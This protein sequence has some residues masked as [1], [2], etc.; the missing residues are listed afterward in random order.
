MAKTQDWFLLADMDSTK[1]I[2]PPEIFPT[3]E[4]SHKNCYPHREN[5]SGCEERHT[6]NHVDK[7]EKYNKLV[8]RGY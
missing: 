2:I 7:V 4:H 8:G 1:L 3:S 5:T 6:E